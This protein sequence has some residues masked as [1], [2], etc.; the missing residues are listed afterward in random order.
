[1]LEVNIA[2]THRRNAQH[3]DDPGMM[4]VNYVDAT[5]KLANELCQRMNEWYKERSCAM[6]KKKSTWL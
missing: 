5:F 6:L 1:M 2:I 4:I 3:G